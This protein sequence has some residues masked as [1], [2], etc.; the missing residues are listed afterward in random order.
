MLKRSQDNYPAIVTICLIFIYFAVAYVLLDTSSVYDAPGHTLAV[1]NAR[2]FWPNWHG[3][4]NELI[5]WS[6]GSTYPPAAHWLMAGLSFFIGVIPAIKTI[7]LCSLLLLPLSIYLYLRSLNYRGVGSFIVFA[8][9][10]TILIVSPDYFGSS[11]K[12]LFNL[13]LI[14]NFVALPILFF[15]MAS[16]E[17]YTKY[18]QPL[19]QIIPGILLG[20]LLWFHLVIAI[21]GVVYLIAIIVERAIRRQLHDLLS[22]LTIGAIGLLV[23]SPFLLRMLSL[24]ADQF[25]SGV[26][27]PSLI[28]P[29]ALTLIFS[30][31]MMVHLNMLRRYEHARLALISSFFAL[32]CIIDG[33]LYHLYGTSF[34]LGKFSLY[35]FQIFA[36]L[37]FVLSASIIFIINIQPKTIKSRWLIKF[38]ATAF[39]I[40]IVAL[41]NPYDFSYS[42]TSINS[43]DIKGRYLE[44]FS[45]KFSYPSPYSFQTNLTQQNPNATWAY[46][47][48]VE[49]TPNSDFIKSLSRSFYTVSQPANYTSPISAVV[50]PRDRLASTLDLFSIQNLISLDNNPDDSIGTW[51]NKAKTMYYH[52]IKINS[53]SVIEAPSLQLIPVKRHWKQSIEQWWRERGPMRTLPYDASTSTI[54]K[55]NTKKVTIDITS[56]NNHFISMNIHSA[57]RVPI[58]IKM[59]YSKEWHAYANGEKLTIWKAAP[60][61]MLIYAN[62]QVKITHE[63]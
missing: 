5:G 61:L 12:S 33:I 27:I 29:N 50:L 51:A 1:F 62:G 53:S 19:R 57:K 39:L 25:D 45:R 2:S 32:V 21:I 58:L 15:F 30:L 56:F 13:G 48:F 49:S 28:I 8:F 23:S 43:A 60:S 17:V 11:I 63:G 20:T 59:A 16:A 3:W 36:Y 31:L 54:P 22:L 34:A 14:T 41:N 37:F 4:S 38:G 6:Q 46:G 26:G 55:T 10:I 44:I 7:V 35:R 42:S 40:V 18:K 9:L 52:V 24:S 47:L